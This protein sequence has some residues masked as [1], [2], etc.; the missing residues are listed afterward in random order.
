MIETLQNIFSSWGLDSTWAYRLA[1]V[2]L[3]IGVILLSVT[4][5]WVAKRFI[6]SAV[7]TLVRKSRTS[8]DDTFVQRGVFRKLSHLAPALVIYGFA[9]VMFPAEEA[10]RVFTLHVAMAYMILVGAMVV[11]ATFDALGDIYDTYDIS[12]ERPIK[13][14]IQLINILVYGVC[15][16][17][18]LST[19]LV[20]SP[21]ALLSGLGALTAILLLVFKDSILGFVAGIQLSTQ[22]MVRKGD[23]VEMPRYGA[24]GDVIDISL[25]TVKVQNFDKTITTIPTYAL[26]S[27]SFKNWRGMDE[28]S[29]RRIKR[30]IAI[31]IGSVRFCDAETIERF[32]RVQL[33][34]PYITERTQEIAA[35]N[36]ESGADTTCVLNGRRLTNLGVFRQY[37]FCYLANHP[38]INRDMTF[39]V[40]QLAPT[41]KGVPIQVYVFSADKRWAQYEAIQGD[42][43]DHIIA[44]VPEFGLRIFQNPS[45]GDLKNF[46]AGETV[47]ADPV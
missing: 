22:D 7:S 16:I 15:A 17:L 36:K 39:L 29:G 41:E 2:A 44:A 46:A 11:A 32:R 20:K 18:V 42:I 9:V 25:T 12:R 5:N 3:V 4:A 10:L 45:G 28:S 30:S 13:S 24:D 14:F 19:L 31:D 35:A 38:L 8:W 40:R 27:D 21:W 37:V 26:V 23:W 43:F 1:Q 33:L 6:V 47:L 34:E